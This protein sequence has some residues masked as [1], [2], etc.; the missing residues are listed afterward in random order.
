MQRPENEIIRLRPYLNITEK[1]SITKEEVFQNDVIRP[2]MKLQHELFK[3]IWS[4]DKNFYRSTAKIKDRD[5]FQHAVKMWLRSQK[6]V[7][8]TFI[9]FVVGMMKLD[10][11]NIYLESKKEFDK[12]IVAMLAQRITDTVFSAG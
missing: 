10:E 9:G 12:R 5:Q 2:I 6:D 4:R 8:N 11:M 3:E 1:D 7:R